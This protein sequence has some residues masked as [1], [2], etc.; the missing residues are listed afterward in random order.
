MLFFLFIVELENIQKISQN[1]IHINLNYIY[2]EHQHSYIKCILYINVIKT[3]KRMR[4]M[5]F[6]MWRYF[7]NFLNVYRNMFIFIK[8]P[9]KIYINYVILLIM[10]TKKIQRGK[11]YNK[12]YKKVKYINLVCKP[13]LYL[14]LNCKFT[15]KFDIYNKKKV[16]FEIKKSVFF[17]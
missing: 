7:I 8:K 11:K 6:V 5:V 15:V 17:H 16:K 10:F 1:M 9:A 13:Y 2:K 14:S 12:N 3:I 4:H